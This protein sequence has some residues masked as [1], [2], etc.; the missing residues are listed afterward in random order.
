MKQETPNC[1]KPIAQQIRNLYQR[2][3][4]SSFIIAKKIRCSQA[5]ADLVIQQIRIERQKKILYAKLVFT[6]NSLT[7]ASL[8]R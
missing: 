8:I 2:G 4:D 3:D 1:K 5:Y 7:D 6:P